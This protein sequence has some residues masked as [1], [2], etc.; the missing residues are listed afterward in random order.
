MR[1]ASAWFGALSIL[2]CGVGA[3][4]M[5]L[6]PARR[7]ALTRVVL[8][9][10]MDTLELEK[11]DGIWW[12][13]RLRLPADSASVN[14]DLD[15]LFGL[16]G[17]QVASSRKKPDLE[18]Y[19][20]H[21]E[22]ARSAHLFFSSGAPVRLRLGSTPSDPKHLY[23]KFEGKPEIFREEG[24][25]G[26]VTVD[27]EDAVDRHLVPS[28]RPVEVET[29]QVAWVDSVGREQGYTLF[30]K[31]ADTVW[32]VA[33]E[34]ALLTGV[35]AWEVLGQ[36]PLMAIDGF[37]APDE[38]IPPSPAVPA[39]SIRLVLKDGARY[40]VQSGAAEGSYYY[41]R[42]PLSG[43]WVKVKRVRLDGFRF[44]MAYLKAGPELGPHE[45][46]GTRG[47][48]DPPSKA[49]GMWAPHSDDGDE[50]EHAEP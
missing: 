49:F 50:E 46:D 3:A 39:V 2:T 37:P 9:Y 48:L 44:T 38:T 11:R 34:R 20:L 17:R 7:P 13:K 33:P 36:T 23:W 24:G 32:M 25:T 42:H 47:R 12:V 40:N 15:R 41:V 22:E 5:P 45:D 19:G 16:Q 35:K 21:V 8:Q 29:V 18:A 31:S 1:R 14:A 6:D 4:A 30:Q 28:I 26:V 10:Q 27:P 43:A